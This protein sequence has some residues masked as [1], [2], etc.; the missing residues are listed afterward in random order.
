MDK[1][2]YTCQYCGKE[3]KPNRRYKQRFCSCSCRVNSHIKNKKES[4]SIPAL[5]T[6]ANPTNPLKIEKMSW[7]GVGN[8]VAGT[9]A[10][11]ALSHLITKE[12]NR[13]ATKKDV[14]EIITA[15][16]QR[17]FIIKNMPSKLDGSCSFF[18]MQTN[19][20]V[21]LKQNKKT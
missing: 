4:L 5:G 19:T 3:Y 7:A 18:D 8:N 20:F 21:Y 12:E 2:L 14:K 17:Y 11:N 10:V 16:K 1:Y 6:K 13:P 15:L 9:L